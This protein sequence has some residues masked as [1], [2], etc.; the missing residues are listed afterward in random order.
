M[1]GLSKSLCKFVTVYLEILFSLY[2]SVIVNK[3]YIQYKLFQIN[4]DCD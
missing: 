4:E 3:L 2:K 1:G